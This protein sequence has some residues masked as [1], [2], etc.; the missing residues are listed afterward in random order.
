M[1]RNWNDIDALISKFLAGEASPEEAMELEDWKAHSSENQ[2]YYDSCERIFFRVPTKN[3][4]ENAWK[5]VER[6]LELKPMRRISLSTW[7]WA[8]TFL[9]L[10]GVGSLWFLNQYNFS[11]RT[12]VLAGNQ[13]KNIRLEDGSSVRLQANTSLEY[14]QN[15]NKT[16]RKVYLKGSAYFTVDHNEQKPFI[17][18]MEELFVKDLGTKFTIQRGE[19]TIF[20]R[21]DEGE[22]LVYNHKNLKIHLQANESAY[23][24]ISNGSFKITVENDSYERKGPIKLIFEKQRLKSVIE[25]LKNL[26]KADIRLGNTAIE[27]CELTTEFNDEELEFVLEIIAET[28]GLTLEK[29]DQFYQ[30]NGQGC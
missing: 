7:A 19:D 28:L 30:L 18:E 12:S 25:S 15:Y 29:K 17:V 8:A 20:I 14:D 4:T 5:K 2:A 10:V 11:D 26:Y 3:G 6:E 21:V 9:L 13:C 24:V 23:Y 27:N 16:N 1:M 22:V